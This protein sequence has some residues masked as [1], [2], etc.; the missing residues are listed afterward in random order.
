MSTYWKILSETSREFY[1]QTFETSTSKNRPRRTEILVFYGSRADSK[2]DY[3]L[4]PRFV[5]SIAAS[6]DRLFNWKSKKIPTYSR[7]K[8]WKAFRFWAQSERKRLK[9]SRNDRASKMFQFHV[10]RPRAP[11]LPTRTPAICLNSLNSIVNH[12]LNGAEDVAIGYVMIVRSLVWNGNYRVYNHDGQTT[13]FLATLT[14]S[15]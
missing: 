6:F 10:R 8:T 14:T 15:N 1:P 5:A 2:I 12:P 11:R 9:M 3:N 13:Q 4:L 7:E